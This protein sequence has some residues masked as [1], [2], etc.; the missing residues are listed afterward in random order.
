MWYDDFKNLATKGLKTQFFI[1]NSPS[2]E[3]VQFS[4]SK[5]TIQKLESCVRHKDQ[6]KF[7]LGVHEHYVSK[8][9]SAIIQKIINDEDISTHVG[10]IG[11]IS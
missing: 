4:H 10:D 11:K 6:V 3:V 2:D 1:F 7:F 8:Y 5:E 9:D